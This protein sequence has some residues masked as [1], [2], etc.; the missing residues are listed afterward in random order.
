MAVNSAAINA[1]LSFLRKL[2]NV[3]R[4]HGATY[5]NDKIPGKTAAELAT[6]PTGLPKNEQFIKFVIDSDESKYVNYVGNSHHWTTKY[7]WENALPK[8]LEK[9]DI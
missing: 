9:L 2:K 3:K 8:I 6:L 5:R 1:Y 7:C 4:L